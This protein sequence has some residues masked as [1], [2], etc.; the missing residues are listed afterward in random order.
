MKGASIL[1]LRIGEPQSHGIRDTSAQDVAID[2]AP[3]RRRKLR[4]AL[5][6]GGAVLALLLLA[7]PAISRWMNA[8]ISVAAESVRTA[9][10]VRGQFTR[11]ISAQGTVV[12]AVSPAIFSPA[13]GTVTYQVQAGDTVKKGQVLG[14][15]DSPQ[16]RNEYERESSSLQSLEIGLQRSSIETR[17]KLLTNQQTSDTAGVAIKAAEREL[18]RAEEAWKTKA[19]SQRDWE[20]AHDDLTTARLTHEHAIENAALE[21]ESLEFE[22]RTG[23]LE[24]DRQRLLVQDLKRRVDELTFRSPVDGMVGTLAVNQ[25]GTVTENGS[26]LTVVDLSAFEIEFQMPESYADDINIGMSADAVYGGKTYTA[27]VTSISPEVRQNQ[28]TGRMRFDG[29][30]PPGLRQNQRVSTRIVLESRPNVLKVQRGR[31]VDSGAGRVAY[32]IEDG[33]ARRTPV[34]LGGTSIAEI[35]IASGLKEGDEIIVSST[36]SFENAQVVRLVD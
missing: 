3:A 31:W 19:I 34:S 21:K 16:L 10:V 11:D 8:E 24:R 9:K 15:V 17:R 2:P 29:E 6:A 18:K 28:V 36:D 32:V 5:G 23:R 25:K 35:E 7:V 27:K 33:L 20:K 13:P 1:K 26:L 30:V 12:A 22:L 14:V 4:I